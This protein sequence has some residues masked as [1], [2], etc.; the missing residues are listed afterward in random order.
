MRPRWPLLAALCNL[1]CG[2]GLSPLLNLFSNIP[3]IKKVID[4]GFG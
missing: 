1:V 2:F 3:D 4:M